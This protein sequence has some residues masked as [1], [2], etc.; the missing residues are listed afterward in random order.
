MTFPFGRFLGTLGIRQI[1]QPKEIRENKIHG[2][3]E[4]QAEQA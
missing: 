1:L 2:Q 4:Y 3:L